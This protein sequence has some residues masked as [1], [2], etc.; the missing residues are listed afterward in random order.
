M[1]LITTSRTC[2]KGFLRL[3]DSPHLLP[4]AVFVAVKVVVLLSLPGRLSF[5]HTSMPTYRKK[6]VEFIR[7]SVGYLLSDRIILLIMLKLLNRKGDNNIWCYL[8]SVYS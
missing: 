3:F 5:S 1:E 6:V 8:A 4:F 7:S 2:M